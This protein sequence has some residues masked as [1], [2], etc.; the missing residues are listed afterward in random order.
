MKKSLLPGLGYLV[1]SVWKPSA[2]WSAGK[3]G[4]SLFVLFLSVSEKEC[5]G[6][7]IC[8]FLRALKNPGLDC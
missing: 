7:G 8:Q 6:D 4:A 5:K 2:N 1:L 3:T